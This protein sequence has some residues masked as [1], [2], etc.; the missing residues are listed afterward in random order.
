MKGGKLNSTMMVIVMVFRYCV[1][2][3]VRQIGGV[4]LC[5]RRVKLCGGREMTSKVVGVLP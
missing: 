1:I 5:G 2:R 3:D 4:V